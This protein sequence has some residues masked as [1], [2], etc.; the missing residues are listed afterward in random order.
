MEN[1]FNAKAATQSQY[2]GARSDLAVAQAQ[3]EA[4]VDQYKSATAQAHGVHSQAE[5]QQ[6][7]ITLGQA[8]VR[9]REAELIL[10]QT[11]LGYATVSA[12]CDGIISKRAVE[13]GQYIS[14]GAPLCSEIDKENFWVTANFKETQVERIKPGQEVTIKLDAY[15]GITLKGKVESFIG[16]TGAKFS[17]LP[18]DN[19]TGNFVKVVQRIPVRIAVTEFPKESADMLFPGLSAFVEVRVN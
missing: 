16:A 9:Q 2:D 19:S 10:A 6:A 4:A 18:P 5:A 11:Q 1:M 12:P 15:S 14:I 7:Q 3:Y 13:E 17:L 8:L